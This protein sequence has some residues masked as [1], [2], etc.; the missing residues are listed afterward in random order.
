MAWVLLI[1]F[2]QIYSENQEQ[3][4]DVKNLQ[5]H[6]KG[7]TSKPGAKENMVAEKVNTNKKLKYFLLEQ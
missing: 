6:Q 4:A 7:R 1:T 5:F 3:K 2:S